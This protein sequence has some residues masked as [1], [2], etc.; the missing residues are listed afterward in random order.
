MFGQTLEDGGWPEKLRASLRS[1]GESQRSDLGPRIWER[2]LEGWG[3]LQIPWS[4]ES[5]SSEV[6]SPQALRVQ[7]SSVIKLCSPNALNP[8]SRKDLTSSSPKF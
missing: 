2:A 3:G 6:L 4:S 8:S 1:W 7:R 5:P